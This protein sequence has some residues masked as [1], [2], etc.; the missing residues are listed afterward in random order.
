MA[1][2]FELLF[3]DAH[4]TFAHTAFSESVNATPGLKKGL[5]Y[6]ERSR[7]PRSNHVWLLPSTAADE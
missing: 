2:D 7:L 5:R 1:W 4:G 3:A 6:S